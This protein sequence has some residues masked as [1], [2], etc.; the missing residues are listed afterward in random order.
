M[1]RVNAFGWMPCFALVLVV[2]AGLASCSSHHAAETPSETAP[3]L[4]IV[5]GLPVAAEALCSALLGSDIVDGFT[6]AVSRGDLGDTVC[7]WR[8]PH[9]ALLLD[10]FRDGDTHPQSISGIPIQSLSALAT[11]E[12]RRSFSGSPP[13]RRTAEGFGIFDEH[14]GS[15]VEGQG[16]CVSVAVVKPAAMSL[17][18][19]QVSAA[20]SRNL[21]AF[22]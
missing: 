16:V 19:N 18:T 8:A 5:T 1:N 9:G 21:R 2:V 13:L 6:L 11:C 22:T 20:L 17:T 3:V 12:R 4:P 14:L 15:V 7:T 10:V